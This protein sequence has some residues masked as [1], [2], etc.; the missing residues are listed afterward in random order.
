MQDSSFYCLNTI[1]ARD[2]NELLVI[3]EVEAPKSTLNLCT[4]RLE[5]TLIVA[6]HKRGKLSLQDRP[7]LET[8]INVAKQVDIL[9]YP[10]YYLC[11]RLRKM[12][13]AVHPMEELNRGIYLDQQVAK[14][15]L[16]LL[17][18]ILLFIY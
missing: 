6:L 9:D 11:H 10:T 2:K 15:A 12:R 3:S 1:I 16:N 4:A 13:N 7:T 8:L 14:D 17:N 5:E 18:Q